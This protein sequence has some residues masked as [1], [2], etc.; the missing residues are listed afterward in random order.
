MKPNIVG[1]G[2]L[3]VATM[4]SACA[5]V[6]RLYPPNPSVATALAPKV[7][8]IVRELTCELTSAS[9]TY[10]VDKDYLISATLTLQVNDDVNF[11]PSL[12]FIEPLTVAQ[13]NRAYN[14]NFGIGGARERNFSSLFHFDSAELAKRESCKQASG[15][16]YRLDGN[17][18]LAE[19]VRDGIGIRD[20]QLVAYKLSPPTEPSFASQIKFVVTKSVGALG[21]TWTLLTFKGPGGA[22]GPLNGKSLTTDT[23]IVAFSA[24][25]KGKTLAELQLENTQRLVELLTQ[26]AERARANAARQ[27]DATS[28]LKNRLM[29]GTP[30]LKSQIRSELAQAEVQQAEAEQKSID[31][32]NQLDRA[33][34]EVQTL[35]EAARLSRG[36]VVEEALD[37]N[38]NLTNS[39]ILQNINVQ[40]R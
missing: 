21:P 13:T 2:S 5:G 12:S 31:A 23:L 28:N 24:K 3:V 33:Q 35:G 18:G 39:L 8:D 27:R 7:E 20:Q 34:L 11:S 16:F 40:P 1:A 22:T 26:Q 29:E 32:Q 15:K 4:L 6:P 17:L 19:I 10:L 25:K 38:K 30:F 37:A 14:Q 36:R 9:K